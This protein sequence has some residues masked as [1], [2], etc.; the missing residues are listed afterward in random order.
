MWIIIL[1]LILDIMYVRS[2]FSY[3]LALPQ[4]FDK[5]PKCPEF[6]EYSH[7]FQRDVRYGA[8]RTAKQAYDVSK[9]AHT[10]A[11]QALQAT[12]RQELINRN[13]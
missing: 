13:Q 9:L 12:Q 3:F 1:F 5:L 10:R 7:L 8:C 11:Q 4:H 2:D 6:G